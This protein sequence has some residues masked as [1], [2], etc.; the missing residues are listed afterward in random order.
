MGSIATAIVYCNE[1]NNLDED[2]YGVAH[3]L[4]AAGHLDCSARMR[5]IAREMSYTDLRLRLC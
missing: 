2:I 4:T 1:Q 3:D 5:R